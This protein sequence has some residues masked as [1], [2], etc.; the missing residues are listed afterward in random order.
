MVGLRAS[1]C[2]GYYDDKLA[3]DAEKLCRNPY[4]PLT[5]EPKTRLRKKR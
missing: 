3:E 1:D 4:L 5:S 2:E